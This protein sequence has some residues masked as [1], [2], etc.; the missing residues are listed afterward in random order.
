M[1]TTP[2]FGFPY[3]EIESPADVPTDIS[4]LASAVEDELQSVEAFRYSQTFIMEASGNFVKGN[5]PGLRAVRVRVVGGGGSGGGCA[6]TGSGSN[7]EGGGG[8]GGGYAEA[9]I[10][11]SALATSETVTIGAGGVPAAT[12]NNDGSTGGTTSF[13]SHVSA[14]G[15]A[16]GGGSPSSSSSTLAPGGTGGTGSGGYFR[17]EGGRGGNGRIVDGDSITGNFG[18]SSFLSPIANTNALTTNGAVGR[19]YGGGSSGARNGNSQGAKSS[20]G[21]S[22]GICIIDIYV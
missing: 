13:G 2:V 20:L 4:A 19:P 7:A 5:F 17:L 12:G 14:T 11:D 21:G 3:P 6:N 1:G 22:P 10:L 15:G 16:G 8:G 9:F 18:G